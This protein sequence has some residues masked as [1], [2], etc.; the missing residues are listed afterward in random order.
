MTV[1][2]EVVAECQRQEDNALYTAVT[3]LLWLR[4]IRLLKRAYL[5]AQ[6][7]FAAAAAYFAVD[8]NALA[9]GI[10]G[11]IAGVAPSV[12]DALKFDGHEDQVRHY[13]SEFTRL[14]D[15]FRQVRLIDDAKGIERLE[16]SFQS[17]MR[18]M[19][20]ARSG[21]VTPPERLFRAAQKKIKTGDYSHDIAAPG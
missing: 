14:R 6:L 4:E 1:R 12:W 17:A 20:R 3:L 11:S 21:A 9:A 8:G 19:D 5:L 15:R 7:I 10:S 18:Q 16:A 2:N 13:A